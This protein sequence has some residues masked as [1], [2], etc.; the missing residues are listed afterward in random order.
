M[1]N[2]GSETADDTS[3]DNQGFRYK[4]S[5]T[6]PCLAYSTCIIA[7][8][9]LTFY[10]FNTFG[11]NALVLI[12]QA[13]W[14]LSILLGWLPIYTFKRRGGVP[15]NDSYMNTTMLV[16]TGLYSVVRHPQFLA[17]IIVS[18]SLALMSQHWLNSLLFIP[19]LVGTIYDTKKADQRLIKKFGDQYNT[20]KE[21][22]PALNIVKGTLRHLQR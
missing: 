9:V 14:V 19:V 21:K 7:Q 11:Y 18:L 3:P 4:L 5:D 22:V 6:L 2:L 16:D 10:N 1:V 20:Y 8:I 13:L 17:W 15:K 12:G